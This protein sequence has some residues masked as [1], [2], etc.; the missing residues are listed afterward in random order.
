MAAS[1][2][3]SSFS[4]RDPQSARS[5]EK[6]ISAGFQNFAL[7]PAKSFIG[8]LSQLSPPAS[9]ERECVRAIGFSSSNDVGVCESVRSTRTDQARPAAG[10][11]LSGKENRLE[12]L[13]SLQSLETQFPA[14]PGI[15][16]PA[17]RRGDVGQIVVDPNGARVDAGCHRYGVL[18]VG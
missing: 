12:I 5:R 8:R 13:E 14:Q 16:D 9:S 10:K 6:S 11:V 18:V 3:S 4:V 17:V 1:F 7:P 15:L 2:S